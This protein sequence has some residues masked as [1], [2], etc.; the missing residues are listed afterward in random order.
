[1]YASLLVQRDRDPERFSQG[2]TGGGSVVDDPLSLAIHVLVFFSCILK[3][4]I[5]LVLPIFSRKVRLLSSTQPV[6]AR[7]PI[8]TSAAPCRRFRYGTPGTNLSIIQRLLHT[9][10]IPVGLSVRRC[11]NAPVSIIS[12]ILLSL[13]CD[14][15]NAPKVADIVREVL[16][17]AHHEHEVTRHSQSCRNL[18]YHRRRES[19]LHQHEVYHHLETAGRDDKHQTSG[20]RMHKPTPTLATHH[21]TISNGSHSRA[22]PGR[23]SHTEQARR[24]A[25]R[26]NHTHATEYMV[27]PNRT[28]TNK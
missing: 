2:A 8:R 15:A 14:D 23:T 24:A 5:G 18:R 10:Q 7:A 1:M 4:T 13:V 20:A 19:P 17:R 16:I 27:H 22:P 3:P 11:G 12:A 26:E 9:L 28:H 21:H 25:G 6:C